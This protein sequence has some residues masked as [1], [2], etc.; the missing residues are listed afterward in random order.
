VE[1]LSS[2]KLTAADTSAIQDF[3]GDCKLVQFTQEIQDLTIELRQRYKLKLADAA[4]AAT[5]S[6]L[7]VQLV[8]ADKVFLKLSDELAVLFVER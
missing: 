7:G 8:T 6:Y 2:G 3:I 4:V 1:L 5:A